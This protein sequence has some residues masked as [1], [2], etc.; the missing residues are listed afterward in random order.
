MK[1]KCDLPDMLIKG[2]AEVGSSSSLP[3]ASRRPMAV[4]RFL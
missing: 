2:V 1:S 4:L 3:H